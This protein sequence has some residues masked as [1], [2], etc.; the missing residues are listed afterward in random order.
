MTHILAD[1]RVLAGF[2]R[3]SFAT[4]ADGIAVYHVATGEIERVVPLGGIVSLAPTGTDAALAGM[5]DGSVVRIDLRTGERYPV[6]G[7][8]LQ[9]ESEWSIGQFE[10]AEPTLGT[11]VPDGRGPGEDYDPPLYIVPG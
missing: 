3:A 4:T 2:T 5:E 11:P 7:L 9:L 1:G 6:P 8:L 10:L